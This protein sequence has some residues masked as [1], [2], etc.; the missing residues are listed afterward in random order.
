MIIARRAMNFSRSLMTSAVRGGGG[1]H[2]IGGVPGAVSL[3][4][5]TFFV[6]YDK[7]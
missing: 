6:K 7:L 3:L 2:D 4:N 5:I 1:H